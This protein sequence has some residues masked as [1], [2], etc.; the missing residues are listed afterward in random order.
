MIIIESKQ[1]KL[2]KKSS[3]KERLIIKSCGYS[4]ERVQKEHTRI[5]NKTDFRVI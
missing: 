1:K 5:D 3:N 4:Q 2:I